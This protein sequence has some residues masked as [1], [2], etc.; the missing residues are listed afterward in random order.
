[1]RDTSVCLWADGKETVKWEGW[2]APGEQGG[3]QGRRGPLCL[4][5]GLWTGM[6]LA[7]QGEERTRWGH[8]GYRT[9]WD[10]ACLSAELLFPGTTGDEVS[11]ERAAHGG[12]SHGERMGSSE[13][14]AG[15]GGGRGGGS[16]MSRRRLGKERGLNTWE[17]AQ[18]SHFLV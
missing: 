10:T 13:W 6:G 8:R 11:A 9:R 12:E 14:A 5:G 7:S 2:A 18:R 4:G 1:M 16:S 3:G 17:G 15:E